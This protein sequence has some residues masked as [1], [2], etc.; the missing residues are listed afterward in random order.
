MTHLAYLRANPAG[1]FFVQKY[2]D[3]VLTGTEPACKWIKLAVKRQIQDL[4]NAYE[5]GFYFNENAAQHAI[6]FFSLCKHSKGE[7][8][9]QIITLEPWQ[10]FQIWCLFG[11]L[12]LD[13]DYRRFRTAYE[14][15]ARKNGKTTKAAGVGLYLAFF[16]A[17]PGAEVYT[18][19]TKRDQARIAHGEAT[20]MVKASP[21]LSRLIKVYKDNLNVLGTASKFEPLGRDADSMDGLN[22]HG[23]VVDE[24]HAHKTRELWDVLETATGSRR[25]SLM[26]AITT[27]GFNRQ[28]ICY[29]LHLYTK[30][31]LE[32]II[33]DD[34][35]FGL[36]FTLDEGDDWENESNWI[37]ANPNLGVSVKL[38]DL[39]RKAKKAK[40]T[41][42][43][44]NAFLR[45]H[46]NLWTQAETR[47]IPVE[48]WRECGKL[49][50][51]EAELIGRPCYAGL[52]LSSTIDITAWVLVFPPIQEGE[53]YKIL[54]RFFVPEDNIYERS[55][56]DRVPYESWMRQG[57][58]IPTPGNVIDYD[59]VLAQIDQDAQK[60]D[61]R[62]LAFDRWGATKLVNDLA[63]M[64]FEI[65]ASERGDK[66]SRNSTNR[67]LV[68]FGQG[69]ASMNSPT[70]ELMNLILSK[71]LAHGNNPVLTW[72]A[73]NLVVREDPAGNV[74]PDKE[75]S[76]EKIDGIVALIMGLDRAT[77][78]DGG[79]STYEE[80]DLLIL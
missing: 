26:F 18:A 49:E 56:R 69:F 7:W 6:D 2:M 37:K 45:L 35:H 22:V 27:A 77:R 61:L 54:A 9:G 23:A 17:E 4:Q 76:I 30:K 59:F 28:S 68:Q 5:R 65:V 66:K 21:A 40:E 24:V 78:G 47:W 41:P 20:R 16:D 42:G 44:L 48:K 52:D 32:G 53:P 33:E 43:A 62:Q 3:D 80:N 12:R 79:S 74:K 57:F 31:V 36:I 11:W 63:G 70:K 39:K 50:V 25:Q 75:K 64:G 46:M 72:M 60:F 73:D 10:Q 38:D 15:I 58:I 13:D 1:N 34:T 29:E 14:E 55:K 71:R 67:Q 8:G 19:A 51:V